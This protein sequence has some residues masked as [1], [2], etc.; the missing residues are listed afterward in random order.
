MSPPPTPEAKPPADIDKYPQTTKE[1]SELVS[2]HH[3]IDT[4]L[5]VK[6]Q[7]SG[8]WVLRNTNDVIP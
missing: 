7:Q 1:K 8:V 2:M 5:L 4:T 6:H 3:L